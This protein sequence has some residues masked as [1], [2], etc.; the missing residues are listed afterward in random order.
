VL[1][2]I[3]E[4][5]INIDQPLFFYRKHLGSSMLKNTIAQLNDMERIKE[6][7]LRRRNGMEE[8][9]HEQFVEQVEKNLTEDQKKV[10]FKRQKGKFLY[11][12]GAINFVNGRYIP[13]LYHLIL[14]TFFDS[15]LVLSGLKNVIKSKLT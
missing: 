9:S 5:A 14:A 10:R 4:S 15:A 3:F 6:N 2:F 12:V 13:G 7:T 11:R 8:I 1:H